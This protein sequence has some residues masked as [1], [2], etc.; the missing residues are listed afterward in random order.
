MV[1]KLQERVDTIDIKRKWLKT[2]TCLLA[3]CS[4]FSGL[5]DVFPRY[6]TMNEP[7]DPL[8]HFRV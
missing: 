7:L 6:V 8:L 2:E 5:K 3:V 4:C 1:K